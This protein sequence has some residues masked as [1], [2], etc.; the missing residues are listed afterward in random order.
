VEKSEKWT[1]IPFSTY[2]EKDGSQTVCFPSNKPKTP[3][4]ETAGL[5]LELCRLAQYKVCEATPKEEF[6]WALLDP[7]KDSLL[8]VVA[9]LERSQI[10]P[11]ENVPTKISQGWGFALWYAFSGAS[12]I[13]DSNDFVK[14][15]RITS[16]YS[17]AQGQNAWSKNPVFPVLNRLTQIARQAALKGAARLDSAKKYFKGEA[18]F[19]EKL[20]GKKP[21]GGLYTEDELYFIQGE[22][23]KR[24]DA[25]KKVY[26]LLDAK[27]PD[28]AG[29]SPRGMLA[30]LE[31]MTEAASSKSKHIE[32]A[33]NKRI[34]M[35]LVRPSKG[36]KNQ[37]ATIAP[38]GSLQEKLRYI[39]GG[40]SVRTIA[41]VM[42][43]G[44]LTGMTPATF[45]NTLMDIVR[46]SWTQGKPPTAIVADE[47][48]KLQ[49]DPASAQYL[50]QLRS[51][52]EY[53]EPI[54]TCYLEILPD[55]AD[56]ESWKAVFGRQH[57]T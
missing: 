23:S 35:L 28:L 14:I 56:E 48:E 33:K 18:Y 45:V 26:N 32:D 20:V 31:D 53:I 19:L 2:T 54:V 50:A 44:R 36:K 29:K 8:G 27:L 7:L 3:Q 13:T 10:V 6:D 9:C 11:S 40:D 42:T 55:R 17:V 12:K 30:Y 43:S 15:A 51:V 37:A 52:E 41:K 24:T 38:G 22:W 47:I 49:A 39:N 16:L 25:V 4:M 1:D 5:V 21:Q 34:P 57:G 46:I